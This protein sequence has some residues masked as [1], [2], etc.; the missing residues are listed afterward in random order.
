MG[1]IVSY[2]LMLQKFISQSKRFWNKKK[3]PLC[4]GNISKTFTAS[5]MKKKLNGYVYEFSVD[6]NII[7]TSN[8]IDILK[9]LMKSMTRLKQKRFESES[10]QPDFKNKW[11]ENI[12]KVLM[13]MGV[14]VNLLK[15]DIIHINGGI[16]INVNMSVKSIIYVKKIV[17]GI[18]LHAIVKMEN[19]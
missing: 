14:N 11:I 5:N 12:N 18:L 13:F 3:H 16:M 8:I 17:F 9:Y 10:V 2:L 15:Q 1:A 19:T 4:L 7:D 6:Y